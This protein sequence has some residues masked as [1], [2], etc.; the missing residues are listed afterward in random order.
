MYRRRRG[1]SEH[2]KLEKKKFENKNRPSVRTV[3]L[4]AAVRLRF[5]VLHGHTVIITVYNALHYFARRLC[6]F[7]CWLLYLP[8]PDPGHRR[9]PCSPSI[10]DR[11]I[12]NRIPRIRSRLVY[13]CIIVGGR[14]DEKKKR[15]PR[16]ITAY[17][18][19]GSRYNIIFH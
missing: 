4:A 7:S 3:V 10:P 9:R 14:A 1:K 15:Y 18:I 8:L 13:R 19:H 17:V 6:C 5:F 12:V 11:G 2:K 16:K